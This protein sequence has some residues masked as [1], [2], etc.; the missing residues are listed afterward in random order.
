MPRYVRPLFRTLSIIGFSLGLITAAAPAGAQQSGEALVNS[1]CSGCHE[2]LANG[3]LSRVGEIRKTPEGW[4]MNIVRMMVVHGVEVS[5]EERS[6]LVK[7]LS[8]TQGLAPVETRDWRY[9][10][11]R[12]PAVVE[13]IPDEDLGVMCARC[14][15]WKSVV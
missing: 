7:Y 14:H 9:I 8:D 6:A 3:K 13:S 4:D 12:K 1:R 2:R 11:E 15:S 5:S 10:L